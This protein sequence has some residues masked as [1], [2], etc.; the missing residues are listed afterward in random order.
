MPIKGTGNQRFCERCGTVFSIKPS[1]VASG[2]GRYCSRACSRQPRFLVPGPEAGLLLIPLGNRR[3]GIIDETD[4]LLVAPFA[5]HAHASEDGRYYVRK[6]YPKL[7][8]HR[9][10]LDAPDGMLVDHRDGNGLNCRRNNLRLAT[11][12]QNSA[13][14]GKDGRNL[15]GYKGLAYWPERSKPWAVSIAKEHQSHHIGY[16]VSAEEAAAAYDEAAAAHPRRVCR[17]E[18]P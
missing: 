12:F 18:V 9:L 16:Y 14:R 17:R 1:R 3:F 11:P 6:S 15:S 13:N 10:L 5:W 7:Y 8:L 2:N 4:A